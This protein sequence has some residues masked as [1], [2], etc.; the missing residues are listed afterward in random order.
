[1]HQAGDAVPP[2]IAAALSDVAPG[3]REAMP[4]AA[5]TA[6]A[7][8]EQ[9]CGAARGLTQV[10]A[11]AIGEHVT[12]GILID[13]EP[14]VGAHGLAGGGRLAGAQPG[15]ARGLP[16][17]G[18]LEAEVA[19]AGIVRRLVW[20]IKA[21][22]RSAVADKVDGDLSK[23]TADDVFQA[24]RAGDGVSISVVRDTAKYLGMAVANLAIMLD[25]EAIVLG[26]MIASAGDMLL[27]P[28]RIEC[29]PAAAPGSGRSRPRL[30]CRRSA[31]TPWRLARHARPRAA[32]HDRSRRRGPGAAGSRPR[33]RHPGHS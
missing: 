26:G 24:A 9:W 2:E 17:L 21:G 28:I 27:E 8:A 19:A 12:A 1:M 30:C 20:R 7:I 29:L 3:I 13:G 4:I 22:D 31:P 18:C 6:A 14:W 15:R 25:P 5:G 33:A 10:I 23:I 16:P 11:F 32:P